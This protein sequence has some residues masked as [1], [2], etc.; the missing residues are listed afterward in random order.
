MEENRRRRIEA[1]LTKAL[2]AALSRQLVRDPRINALV[3]ISYVKVSPD[4]RH[5]TVGVSGYMSKTA[6]K[7]SIAGLNNASGFLQTHLSH[8]MRM[9]STP[10]LR[11]VRDT[12]LESG[13]ELIRKIEQN[14][15]GSYPAQ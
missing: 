13:F 11:F 5:A 15:P 10:R 1:T 12:S 6:L 8:E 3:T 7:K 9:R 2:S 4:I 14:A